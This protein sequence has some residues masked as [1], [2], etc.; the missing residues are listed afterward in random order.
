MKSIYL[1]GLGAIG[2]LYGANLQNTFPQ[3][4]KVVADSKRI[5]RYQEETFLINGTPQPFTF[6]SAESLKACAD[7]MLFATKQFHLEAAIASVKHLVNEKTVILSLLNGISSEPILKKHFPDATIVHALCIGQDAVREGTALSYTQ[8]GIIFYGDAEG[9]IPSAL[10]E[11]I[12]DIFAQSGIAHVQSERILFDQWRK[13]MINNCLN[14]I[15]AILDAPYGVFHDSEDAQAL[16]EQIAREVILVANAEGVPLSFDD[17]L[18][19]IPQMKTLSAD[20][21]TSML[22]DARAGRQTEFDMLSGELLRIAARHGL[23][24]PATDFLHHLLK[25]KEYQRTTGK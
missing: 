17:Y 3:S 25:V 10:L 9:T 23:A 7:L 1:V 11:S 2:M 13:F 14:Q 22:Q 6:A 20:G 18:S 4:F 24:L 19:F 21:L 8:H 16:L 5:A 12:G 15:S